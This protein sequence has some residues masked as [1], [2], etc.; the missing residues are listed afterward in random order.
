MSN[1]FPNRQ[2]IRLPEY[3]YSG[4]GLYFITICT[5]NQENLLGTIA[6]GA[7][8]LNEFGKIV[9]NEITNTARMT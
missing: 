4:N 1:D 5:Q 7:M 8:V 2:T 9:E 6:N 3:D